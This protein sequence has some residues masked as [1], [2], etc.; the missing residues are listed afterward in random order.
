MLLSIS[1]GEARNSQD[2]V[3]VIERLY[4]GDGFS[5]ADG[6]GKLCHPERSRVIRF[7][8]HPAESKD[9]VLLS[10]STGAA[11][12]SQDDVGVIERL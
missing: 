4:Q 11:R 2:D 7:A 6:A 1:T 3:G 10:I 12:N 9:P 8:N 5:R